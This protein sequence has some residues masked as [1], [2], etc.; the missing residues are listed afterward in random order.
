ALRRM[1]FSQCDVDSLVGF[2]NRQRIFPIHRSVRFLLTTATRGRPTSA[3][4]CR[5]GETDC[6][7]L[8]QLDD[9]A[10]RA[11]WFP[12]HFPL[13]MLRAPSGDDLAVPDVRTSVDLAI[14]ERAASLFAPLGSPAGWHARFGRELN[15]TDDGH[16]FT[17][18]G[19]GLPVIEGKAI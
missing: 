13:H 6:A 19:E 9:D 16:V 11:S 2:D 12:L 10:A 18:R 4:A 1:L 8:D 15:A 5:L 3:I 7:V 17:H 14:A